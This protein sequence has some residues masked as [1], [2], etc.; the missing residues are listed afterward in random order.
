MTFWLFAIGLG[1]CLGT[2]NFFYWRSRG[3]SNWSNLYLSIIAFFVLGLLF[4]KL[5][6]FNTP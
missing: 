3:Y 6:G 5:L 4:L 1:V 2:I